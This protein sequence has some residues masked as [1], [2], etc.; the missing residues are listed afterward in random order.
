MTRT[1]GAALVAAGLLLT[2]APSLAAD[3]ASSDG[4][5]PTSDGETV[6][7]TWTGVIAPGA[8]PDSTCA[9]VPTADAHTFTLAVP[10]GAYDGVDVRM[11]A[12][13]T[14]TGPSAGAT[15]VIVTLVRPDGSTQ[16]GDAGFVGTT[17]ETAVTNPAAGTYQVLACAFAGVAPQTYEG[18]L[19][20]TATAATDEALVAGDP[21]PAPAATP[22]FEQSYIDT[23]RA[24]GEPIIT[25]HPE[26]QLLWGSHAGTTHFYTPT[27]PSPTTGAFVENYQGQTYYYV[28]EDGSAW[29][30]V[31]RVGPGE[32]DVAPVAGIPATGFSDPEFAIDEAGNVY[33][34]EINLANVAVSKSTDGGRTYGL[35][36]VFSFTSSD[37]QWMAA[38]REDELYM[39]ANGFGGGPFP[40]GAVG[41][42]GHFMAKSTDGGVTFGAASTTNPNGVGDIQIDRERGILY[43]M[44][45][46]SDT[47]G[48]A[49]FPNIRDEDT[50]FTVEI[51]EIASGVSLSG[52]QRLI[53]PTFD[54]DDE[55]NLYVT[56]SDNGGGERPQGIYYSWSTDQGETWALPTRVDPTPEAD[57]WPWITVGAPGQVAVTWLQGDVVVDDQLPGQNGGDEV[58]WRV[59]VATTSTGLGCADGDGAGFTVVNASGDPV[60]VGT[61]C[62]GGTLCQ[63]QAIDRRLGDYFSIVADL[64][65]DV[66]VA[67]SD[68]R[69]G[70]AVSLPLHIRQVAGAGLDGPVAAG[71]EVDPPTAPSTDGPGLPATGGGLALL[72]LGAV[73]LAGGLRG[74]RRG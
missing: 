53:D 8:A 11:V 7:S 59:A 30:F 2:A 35:Q 21:C 48:I 6:T 64:D 49:R 41:E 33:V 65:G 5:A 25:V 23:G 26:G 60:H 52:V 70:G 22:K 73:A 58:E 20:L 34:S 54:M 16:S 19:T 47:I 4:T 13:V 71:P 24:G 43:E 40:A 74:R 3:P 39:T 50:D 14:P 38:D 51:F 66:H 9:G 72:G 12:T 56:W 18:S 63:A 68:T 10:A 62:Q 46:T 31:P 36:N 32:G 37:R 45:V 69:Q 29:S 57:V 44:S 67:V 61:I 42:L 1:A 27:A 15:D 55:G 17:E 28:S